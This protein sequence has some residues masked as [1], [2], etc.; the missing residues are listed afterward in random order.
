MPDSKGAACLYNLTEGLSSL[1]S[2]VKRG[3]NWG[4]IKRNL[5]AVWTAT[6]T[7]QYLPTLDVCP[8]SLI[9]LLPGVSKNG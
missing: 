4:E 8:V 5:S 9:K 2:T 1:T 3:F 7:R 6:D